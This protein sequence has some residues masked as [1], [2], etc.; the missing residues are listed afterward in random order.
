MNKTSIEWTHRPGTTGMTWNPIRFRDANGTVG[1]AC[2]HASP[3]CVNCYAEAIN[4]RLGT[5]LPFNVPSLKA[6]EFFLDEKIL[7][8]PL[9][10]KKPCTIFVGD[11]FDLFHEAIPAEMIT[12]VFE[13]MEAAEQHTFQVLTKRASRIDPVLY[14]EEGHSYLGGGDYVGNVWMGVSV[15]SQKYAD[16]R[17]PLLLQT[18]AAVRFLSVEPQLEVVDL[19]RVIDPRFGTC[20]DIDALSGIATHKDDNH[21]TTPTD[22]ID[23][24]ICGGESGPHA[25][26]FNLAWAESLRDQCKAAGVA[27]FMKQAG[28]KPFIHRFRKDVDFKDERMSV[29]IG[30]IEI[31]HRGFKMKD[32]KGGDPSE[33]PE[34]LR[35]REFPEARQAA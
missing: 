18:P 12:S 26:P 2:T 30:S 6:G 11:M 22:K 25:R 4:K 24:V 33:W 5:G 7:Q 15:E 32:R 28:S 8:Q 14:G 35:V 27:F 34:S 16:E 3:G 13:V 1:W 31:S 17:I 23:W 20:L 19:R 9:K 29:K 10:T 21:S